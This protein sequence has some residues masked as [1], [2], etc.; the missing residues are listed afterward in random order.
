[1]TTQPEAQARPILAPHCRVITVPP[2]AI[3]IVSDVDDLRLTGELFSDLS[4]H[5][6]G[7]RTIAEITD[8]MVANGS[9]TADEV[10]A[11]IE[12]LLQGGF[13]VDARNHQNPQDLYR[14]WWSNSSAA[15][16]A[17]VH[18]VSVGETPHSALERVLVEHGFTLD[19]SQPDVVVLLTDDY[20]NPELLKKTERIPVP[21]LLAMAAGVRPT[22]G[23]W[24]GEPGPCYVCLAVRLQFNRQVEADALAKGDRMGPTSRGWT[25][26]TAAHTASEIALMIERR[27]RGLSSSH[28]HVDPAIANLIVIDHLTGDRSVH[29]VVR[30]PQCVRCGSRLSVDSDHFDIVLQPGALDSK[31]DGAYRRFTPAQTL[32]TY[33][34]HVSSR[35]GVV[36]RLTRISP[37]D[38]VVHIVESGINLAMRGKGGDANGF[39]QNAGG[40]G[41]TA[42]QASAGALAE[43]IERYSCAYSPEEPTIVASMDSLGHSAIDPRTMSLF[44]ESQ[45]AM[46][47]QWNDEH[48]SIHHVPDEFDPRVQMEWSP[49]WSLREGQRVWVPTP[50]AYYLYNGRYPRNGCLADSN[51]NAAGTSIEDA[52][53]QGFFEL[54][55]RDAVAIWWY[56]RIPRPGVDLDAYRDAFNEAYID[57]IRH[58]YS[59]VLNRD[60]W[61]L[62]LTADLGIPTF[63]ALSKARSGAPKVLLGFG[64]HRDARGALLRALT[65]MNQMLGMVE[66]LDATDSNAISDLREPERLWWQMS[67][68]TDHPH[69]I[70]TGIETTPE[71]HRHDWTLDG[72]SNVERALE[73]VE[74]EGM[75]M[76][77][78][79]STRP[80]VG[81]PVVK[82]MVPGMRHFW[83]RYAPGRLYDVPVKLG[84]LDRPMTEAELNP[85]PIFW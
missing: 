74:R 36:D 65:E 48:K 5:L 49:A 33:S 81:L 59:K 69:V 12:I 80:D 58:H 32:T 85:T 61:A 70:P 31:D 3:V 54:V 68:L 16:T 39:R 15:T 43:A 21:V 78:L 84:W 57:S 52:I 53:L 83:P 17:K 30:R 7:T 71:A 8:L 62:D 66:F 11:A 79:N 23:P 1:M 76:H 50:F 14:L 73:L 38:S 26:S 44:S 37:D 35:T 34:H 47:A 6:D 56:N 19:S 18:V 63:V 13:I 41:T 75:S 51:G 2:D 72:K 40:K 22:V 55:E 67:S 45:Y 4:R 10:P 46:R 28:D 20:L 9:A 29:H 24:L 42:E 82:V 60:V 25:P 27:L 77:V 64:A